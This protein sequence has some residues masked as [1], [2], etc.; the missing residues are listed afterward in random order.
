VHV[1]CRAAPAEHAAAQT[2][3]PRAKRGG[4]RWRR[5]CRQPPSLT[6]SARP[7][8]TPPTTATEDRGRARH[9]PP[10]AAR[11]GC[12][13]PQGLPDVGAATPP[14]D[15]SRTSMVSS[16]CVIACATAAAP[17]R[18]YAAQR[19]RRALIPSRAP[20]C[21]RRRHTC[22][23]TSHT[24]T[25]AATHHL[26]H[27]TRSLD[28]RDPAWLG[29]P[30]ALPRISLGSPSVCFLPRFA[31]P[32]V[33]LRCFSH[34]CSAMLLPRLFCEFTET[35]PVGARASLIWSGMV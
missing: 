5:R 12:Y 11:R 16:G 18:L 26:G 28:Y 17:R 6:T 22:S 3:C 34:G 29:S 20:A 4:G 35:S 21:G 13:T 9:R 33:V 30:T 15:Y 25:R 10:A 24:Q 23:G 7:S 19:G 31:S 8:Q 27:H 1:R 2:A 32:T 14:P